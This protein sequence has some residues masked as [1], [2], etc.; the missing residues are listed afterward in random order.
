MIYHNWG[1]ENV[2]W[3]GIGEVCDYF[4]TMSR[5]WGRMGGQIKEK[6]GTVRFYVH[7]GNL[8]LHTL[9][10]PGWVSSQFPKWLWKADI[11]YIGPFLRFFFERLFV[12]WQKYVYNRMYQQALKR[13]PHLRAEILCDADY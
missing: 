6:Y 3:K 10:Y 11:F 4:W 9:F 7:F 12:A 2:D 8:S 13:W 1:D 5:R